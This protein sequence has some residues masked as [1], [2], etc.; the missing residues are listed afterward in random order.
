MDNYSGIVNNKEQ[1]LQTIILNNLSY[2]QNVKK[3]AELANSNKNGVKKTT[4]K[5]GF[6][7]GFQ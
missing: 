4:Q 7:Q 5:T 1:V 2:V 3:Q 6:C